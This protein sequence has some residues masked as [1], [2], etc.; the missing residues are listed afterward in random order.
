MICSY[1][2]FAGTRVP[3]PVIVSRSSVAVKLSAGCG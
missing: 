2:N 3:A 1:S